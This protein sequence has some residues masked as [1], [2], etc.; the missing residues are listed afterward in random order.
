MDLWGLDER[1][2]VSYKN[3]KHEEKEREEWLHKCNKGRICVDE[4]V[5]ERK[6]KKQEGE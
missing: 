4:S 1:E 5:I 3:K 6:R 2:V